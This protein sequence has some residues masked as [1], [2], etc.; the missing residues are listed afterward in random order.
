[1][2]STY[3]HAFFILILLAG[4]TCLAQGIPQG[5]YQQNCKSVSIS[6]DTLIATCQDADG[7]WRSTQLQGFANCSSEIRNENGDLRC[8][9]GG[10]SSQAGGGVTPPGSYQQSCRNIHVSS[11]GTLKA[12]CQN[13]AGNWHDTSLDDFNK[14]QGDI[15]NDSGD[16]H[17]AAGA[18]VGGVAGGSVASGA[19]TG[20]YTQSCR[21]VRVDGNDLHA[22]CRTKSG[23]MRDAKL[24]DYSS[25]HGDIINDD[26]HLHCAS[27]AEGALTG[28]AATA[29]G[30]TAAT[31]QTIN[32][33]AGPYSQSCMDIRTSGDS[34]KARCRSKSGDIHDTSLDDYKK[35]KSDIIN[36]DGNLRCQK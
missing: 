16:L 20:S 12:E 30:A 21:E 15:I 4:A 10:A 35:C 26:G 14:C 36:D 34:L 17:C 23:T 9:K 13:R 3:V 28:A 19:P 18:P 1:M 29:G 27:G 11:S 5:S 25:C 32:A 24:S 31:S 22:R 33:P 7:H 8:D 6:G 2:R